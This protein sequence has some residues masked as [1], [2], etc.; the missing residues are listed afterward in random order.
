MFL[1]RHAQASFLEGN[2][3]KLSTIGEIQAHRLGEFWASRQMVLDRVYSG[4]RVRQLNTARIVRDAYQEAGL[5]FPVPVVMN[6]FDEYEGEVVLRQS[7][8]RLL[9]ESSE[10]REF[11]QRFENS[12]TAG[13]QRKSFQRLF[14]AVIGK[15]VD[16]AILVPDVESWADFCARVGRGLSQVASSKSRGERVAIFSSGGPIGV[17]MP[18]ALNLSPQDTLRVAWM[19]RNCSYS[20]FL[21]SGDRFTLS[22]FNAFPHLDDAALLTSRSRDSERF[23][24]DLRDHPTAVRAGE[25]LDLA[26]LEPFLL[27]HFPGSTGPL[28]VEQF[29]SGHSNLTYLVRLGDREMVLRRPPFGSKVKTAH[30]MG[31]EY[32]VLSKLHSA[33]PAAPKVLLYCDDESIL[34]SPFYLM[35]P[36]RG[37]II[38]RDPPTALSFTAETARRLSESFIDNLARL[39]A[40]DYV[41]IGLGDLGKPQGYLER[42]SAWLKEHMSRTSEAALIHN[43]YKYDNIVLDPADITRIVGVLD[44]EMATI[45]DPLTDLGTALAYWVDPQDP[46]ELQ[47]IRWCPSTYAGSLTRAQLV[48]RYARATGRDVSNM[49]FYLAFARFKVAVIVQQI[50]YRYHQGLTKDARFAALLDVAKILLRASVRTVETGSI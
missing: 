16:G 4:P 48:E 14:E 30:D 41:A 12:N 26:R 11:Y 13:E 40:L 29:P 32:R 36:I 45:G 20:E 39:H 2:Y 22:T 21:F 46:D 50:Y 18:R 23:M 28:A 6:E 47:K 35:E 37:I 10:I 43:D 15:W 7:L 49:V 42:I 1:I 3:D 44:W 33:Y 31:R 5:E 19:S 17:A 38:R 34:G 24:A 9:E 8:A 27:S 25:E